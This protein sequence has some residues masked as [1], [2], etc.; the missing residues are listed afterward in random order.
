MKKN[1]FV[2]LVSIALLVSIGGNLYQQKEIK[3]QSTS[4]RKLKANQTIKDGHVMHLDKLDVES[5]KD[6][7]GEW[8]LIVSTHNG[9]E[10]LSQQG[11]HASATELYFK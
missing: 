11:E 3:D 4:I 1:L 9:Q 10:L 6:R 8:Q 7:G 5:Y 2:G